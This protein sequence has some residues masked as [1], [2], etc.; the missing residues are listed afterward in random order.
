M[1]E[2]R[3]H[4]T[5]WEVSTHKAALFAIVLVLAAVCG[6]ATKHVGV[7]GRE[8]ERRELGE[9]SVPTG[10]EFDFAAAG[11][12]D[13]KLASYTYLRKAESA[14]SSCPDGYPTF[15]KLGEMLRAWSPNEPDVPEGGV[16]ERLQ[17][18]PQHKT[19]CTHVFWEK[20]ILG[21]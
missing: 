13:R 21:G 19:F 12:A 20:L 5:M 6:T 2:G 4:R 11:K 15:G 9:R 3:K 8:E 10:D 1:L 14:Y 17:V 18:S 16:I 7:G